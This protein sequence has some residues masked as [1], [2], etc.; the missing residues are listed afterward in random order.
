MRY[1]NAKFND[2]D[3]KAYRN[4][5]AVESDYTT[6]IQ[7]DVCILQDGKPI[8]VYIHR[9]Q[10]NLDG[11]I[12]ACKTIRYTHNR[13]SNGL[14]THSRIFG[15]APRNVL[16]NAPCRATGMQSEHFKEHCAVEEAASI[17]HR[18]YD[19][20][21]PEVAKRHLELVEEKVLPIYRLG[22]SP[23]TSGIINNNNPLLYHFDSGNFKGV[24]SAMFGVRDGVE[25]GHLSLPELGLGFHIGDKSLTL[26]DGQA[27][28]HGVTP[29]TKMRDDAVRYTV[30][31]YSLQQMWNCQQPTDEIERLRNRRAQI[32]RNRAN[33]T[34]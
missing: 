22:N 15:Y 26:F 19:T 4:R 16:R 27:L 25:G 21:N 33:P 34:V 30:V 20:Y 24:W 10:E 8:L 12:D 13:R 6:L 29:I 9:L 14:F 11:L 3:V 1:L 2:V 23:Y 31:F 32:E 7:D 5:R 17:A 28:L 18:Y